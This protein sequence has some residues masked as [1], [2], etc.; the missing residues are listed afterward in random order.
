MNTD[1][2][3]LAK[4]K[5]FPD[6]LVTNETVNAFFGKYAQYVP[7][8]SAALISSEPVGKFSWMCW[9]DLL[10]ANTSW[11]PLD[12]FHPIPCNTNHSRNPICWPDTL[13]NFAER[14]RVLDKVNRDMIG[15]DTAFS[16]VA[17]QVGG[18]RIDFS[19]ERVTLVNILVRN[20]SV[21]AGLDADL[22]EHRK[23][24]TCVYR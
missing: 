14:A 21:H 13:A 8:N 3:L 19:S 15:K 6:I 7:I 18:P 10:F 20:L 24:T 1:M 12:I 2:V 5:L 4:R 9:P 17:C 11:R 23:N 22:L 16:A